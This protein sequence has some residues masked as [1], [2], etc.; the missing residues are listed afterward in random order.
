MFPRPRRVSLGPALGSL[1]V[2]VLLAVFVAWPVARILARSAEHPG[3]L[4]EPSVVGLALRSLGVASVSTVL[5][6]A[7]GALVACGITDTRAPGTRVASWVGWLPWLTPPFSAALGLRLLLGDGGLAPAVLGA[8]V[9]VEGAPGIV[10]AQILT[11]LP[12]TALSIS[13][14]LSATDPALEEAAVNLGARPLVVLGRITWPVVRRGL[15]SAVVS[16]FAL[17]LGDFASPIVIGGTFTVLTTAIYTR[18]AGGA[19]PGSAA[20]LSVVLLLPCLAVHV[21]DRYWLAGGRP[22]DGAR[23]AAVTRTL[24]RGARG[25]SIALSACMVAALVVVH[26]AVVLGSV[27]HVASS[28]TLGRFRATLDAAAAPVIRSVDLAVFS[29]L[30]GALLAVGLAHALARRRVAGASAL[31]ALALGAAAVPGTVLG[32]AYV[33]TFGGTGPIWVLVASVVFWRLGDPLD[34]ALDVLRREDPGLEEAAQSLGAG[35]LRVFSAVTLPR[36]SAL[37]A[38]AFAGFFSDGLLTVSAVALLAAS[39][40]SPATVAALTHIGRGEL[41]SAAV[42][43]TVV[44]ALAV[45]VAAIARGVG[46]RLEALRR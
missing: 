7:L 28:L 25:V 9:H 27:A 36:L 23:E 46:P 6:V 35:T 26:G 30:V 1:A 3:L 33:V 41:G 38:R 13:A 11:F 15:T 29:G 40:G 8:P 10:L 45:G 12:Y 43:T 39:S 16:V 21:L 14:V 22:V 17:C 2:A 5:T 4:V 18:V 42:L 44:S 31:E 32:L 19:D 37:G 20:A 34:S 24:P